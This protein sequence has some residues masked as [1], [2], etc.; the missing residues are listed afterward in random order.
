MFGR[1]L[2]IGGGAGMPG[3]VRLAA[4]SALRV[5]AGL[6]TV[7]SLPEHLAAVVGTRPELM[8]HGIS[9]CADVVAPLTAAD[10]IAIGPGLGRSDW[11]RELLGQVLQHRRSGQ[12]LVVDA[13]AL[14]LIAD[15]VGLQHCADWV[16]T[17]HPGEAARLLGVDTSVVQ[18]NRLAAL[19]ML[20]ERRGGTIVLKG[21][22]TLVGQSGH[23]P[24]LCEKG[25][26]GMAVPG[27]GDVLTG[28]L[29]GVLAQGSEPL[30]AA[31]AA[32]YAHAVAGDRCARNGVRGVLA[33]DVA[34]E[35]RAVLALLP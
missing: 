6:V 21:A 17:P 25:N 20:C 26:P 15:G 30:A 2:V 35:L 34:Q 27:M 33:L 7:A 3:A 13:D 29:A 18:E 1:V 32:V 24:R 11:A 14:N 22:A 12:H 9:T 23:T 28:A 16:L 19:A 5:G 31:A 8:F 10:V 4:E